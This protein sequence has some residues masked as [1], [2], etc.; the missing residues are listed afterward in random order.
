MEQPPGFVTQG[1]SGL[2]CRLRRSLYGLKQSPRAWFG[3]FNTVVQQFGMSRSNSDHSVFFRYN[4]DRC[5]Y[6]VV[7]IDNI[8]ITGNDHDGI[9]QF[10]QHLFSHFQTKDLGKLKYF[11]GIEVA[12]SKTGIAISQR[13][14]A[15]DI[16]EETYMLDC[17]HVDTPMDPNVK[18]VPEQGEPLKDHARYRRLVGKLNYLTITRPDISFAVSMVSQFLQTP[19][20]SHWDAVIR[21]LRY[22]KGAPG[23]GLLYEDKGH[24]Q[25][26]GYSDADWVGFPS[27]RRSTSGYCIMIG[28]N[29]ISWKSKKQSVVARSSAEAEYRAMALATCELIW[30]KQLLQELKYSDTGQMKL[31]YCIKSSFS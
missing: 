21:I 17:R 7:Y 19:Y 18:L 20:S 15:L 24:S 27:D 28:G 9:S 14:Y 23:Q 2:V 11:L 26:V 4:G 30:L 25:I 22:I 10:K 13:K 16:L 29:L 12:Q 1:E 6:L 3:R 31:I 5:I 8:V